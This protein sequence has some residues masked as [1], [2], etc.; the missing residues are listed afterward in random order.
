MNP[1]KTMDM[2]IIIIITIKAHHQHWIHS[3]SY[4]SKVKYKKITQQIKVIQW[5]FLHFSDDEYL[6][7]PSMTVI[8]RNGLQ[9]VF[10]FERDEHLLTIHSKATNSTSYP[11]TNFTF[12]AAVPKVRKIKWFSLAKS[13]LIRRHSISSYIH[14]VAQ[15]FRQMSPVIFI[16]WWNWAIP[17]G[18]NFACVLK[19][20]IF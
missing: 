16:K 7:I 8:D 12:K 4:F 17:N 11:M 13:I 15:R 6:A 20:I 5:N 9:I 3:E 2:I 19:S 18:K 10:T 14:W 1:Y